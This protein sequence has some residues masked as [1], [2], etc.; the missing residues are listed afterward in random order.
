MPLYS[1]LSYHYNGGTS[2]YTPSYYTPPTSF[3]P[4]FSGYSRALSAG[5]YTAPPT[6]TFAAINRHY[7]PMLTTITESAY[8]AARRPQTLTSLTRINS[9]KLSLQSS[10]VAPRPIQINTADIDV[11]SSRYH[12]RPTSVP[13]VK[14]PERIVYGTSS[15]SPSKETTSPARTSSISPAKETPPESPFMPRVD[16][17]DPPHRSTIKR[18]RNIVRLSTMRSRSKSKS[19]GEIKLGLEAEKR[20]Q[21]APPPQISYTHSSSPEKQMKSSWR[22]RFGEDLL[23]KPKD[24]VRKTPG[25]LMIERHIIRDKSEAISMELQKGGM[26][27]LEPIS[28]KSIRR[29]SLV[30]CPSFKDICKDISSDIKDN[31]DLNAGELRQRR[32]SLILEE[33]QALLAQLSA[34]RRSSNESVHVAIDEQVDEPVMEEVMVMLRKSRRKSTKLRPNLAV[35]LV[36]TAAL[37]AALAGDAI[38]ILQNKSPKWKAVVEEVDEDHTVH[39]VFKLPKKK[40][41][42]KSTANDDIK[43]VRKEKVAK[44]KVSKI[45]RVTVEPSQT[46]SVS[47][48]KTSKVQNATMSMVQAKELPKVPVIDE[49]IEVK[50]RPKVVKPKIEKSASGEDF[51]GSIA[52]RETVYYDERRRLQ[53]AKVLEQKEDELSEM[54][55][56]QRQVEESRALEAKRIENEKLAAAAELEL[57][58]KKKEAD[59]L[60]K[61]QR[62]EAEELEKKRKKEAEELAKKLKKEADDLERKRKA[63]EQA[64]IAAA[65]VAASEERKKREKEAE[66]AERKRKEEEKAAQA[67]ENR[68]RVNL[69][70][71]EM[72]KITASL[73]AKQAAADRAVDAAI[74]DNSSKGCDL[75]KTDSKPNFFSESTELISTS[76]EA[77]QSS[78]KAK[79]DPPLPKTTTPKKIK[80][81]T[82]TKTDSDLIK[83]STLSADQLA[84][85]KMQIVPKKANVAT[86]LKISNTKTEE[87]TQNATSGQLNIPCNITCNSDIDNKN[88]KH[89]VVPQEPTSSSSP[90]SSMQTNLN[91]E[92]GPAAKSPETK[93]KQTKVQDFK[94]PKEEKNTDVASTI[95]P[96]AAKSS[97]A[98]TTASSKIKLDVENINNTIKGSALNVS[99][100][101]AAIVRDSEVTTTTAAASVTGIKKVVSENKPVLEIGSVVATSKK[102]IVDSSQV[103][104][105]TAPP[106]KKSSPNSSGV[107]KSGS[108]LKHIYRECS[109]GSAKTNKNDAKSIDADSSD[110]DSDDDDGQNDARKVVSSNSLSKFSTLANLNDLSVSRG[111]GAVS[112]DSKAINQDD[113]YC[114]S[115]EES[116]ISSINIS[117]SD[118]SDDSGGS[119]SDEAMGLKRKHRKKKNKNFDPKKVVKLDQKRKCFIVDEAPKYPLIA[120]PRPL[121]K[122]W[123]YFSESDT[124]SETASDSESGSGSE[125]LP[126]DGIPDT[127]TGS[128]ADIKDIRSSTCSNDSGFEGGTAPASPKKML[129]KLNCPPPNNINR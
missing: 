95:L 86:K 29:H 64:A 96:A 45:D 48:V 2:S 106:A 32:A 25:E 91:I 124:D 93:Q 69:L 16:Q 77:K 14:T 108:L 8:Q 97:P 129:G 120:T 110:D 70:E 5:T 90:T 3:T 6:R 83:K 128:G 67:I 116:D 66:E 113:I 84:Q 63:E 22:D 99:G 44:P 62:K 115:G 92:N 10:Y 51:W 101:N 105:S 100:S 23:N 109:R 34:T 78:P 122:R 58:K 28:R 26:V 41:K 94:K 114:I 56:Q 76:V 49:N 27:F 88:A 119:C 121:Q 104:S 33:E 12:S 7:K 89:V 72:A 40:L 127:T 60:A 102:A 43:V 36:E 37:Q 24:T 107:K 47:N 82:R 79:K 123:H 11:S 59:D 54:I 111:N 98:P 81:I 9:P 21:T 50:L 57:K 30:K 65:F 19:R 18:D 17:N 61:K 15:T 55:A 117:E 126:V 4:S 85:K 103:T 68:R 80:V 125:L 75:Q 118:Y 112:R 46:V 39:K 73:N 87:K 74:E 53:M 38:Q 52:S 31:D 20:L 35:N 13:A 42:V 71:A 1:D